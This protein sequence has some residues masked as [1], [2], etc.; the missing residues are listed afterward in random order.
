VD[1]L[2]GETAWLAANWPFTSTVFAEQDVLERFHVYA[3]WRG[4]ARAA[5]VIG[6]VV[7]GIPRGIAGRQREAALVLASF[8]MSQ[9]AQQHLVERNGWP[10]IRTDAY[11]SVPA[12]LRE[13]SAAIQAALADGF[14]RPSVPYWAEVSEAMNEA[15]RRVIVR[16][17]AAGPVLDAL[18]ARIASAARR[19][20]APYPPAPSR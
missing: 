4:P 3:G 10:A 12:A 9:P 11:A 7:L 15:V 19:A 14:Y 17:E 16:G 6:G 1:Y 13:T 20:G 18:H 8:L 2:Q 5:H